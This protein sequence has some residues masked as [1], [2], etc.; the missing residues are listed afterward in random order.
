MP[1]IIGAARVPIGKANGIYKNTIP[2]DLA[3]V[4]MLHIMN[5]KPENIA[6]EIILAN[7]FGTGGNMA[8][9]AALKAGMSINTVATTIDSQCSGGLRAI[10][11][12]CFALNANDQVLA[13]GMESKSLAP[14]KAYQN[15]DPRK[16]PNFYS[17]EIAQFSP[18]QKSENA[19]LLAA[20]N[21]A[22]KYE[23]QKSEM[24]KQTL[25]SHQRAHLAKNIVAQFIIKLDSQH[26]DQSIRSNISLEFLTKASENTLI[27]RTVAAHYNDGA[28]MILIS[29]SPYIKPL[30]EIIATATVGNEPDLAPEGVLFA[31]EKVIKKSGIKIDDISNFE[32][33]ES[34]ALTPIIFSQYFNVALHK[35]NILG[36]CLAYG[37]PFG[38]SGTIQIIHLIASLKPGQLGLAV[39]PGAG[40]QAT[41]VIIKK[42]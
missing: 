5:K 36:G 20:E 29:N 9:Y 6:T 10:E 39:C 28:A 31:T 19:L 8:R 2:E 12:A 18:N 24:W 7:A 33:N 23:I 1:W 35:I 15:T 22:K 30:A 21:V 26:T 40:G 34:F 3:A 16:K 27:D 4:L 11:M 38:A 14:I 17:Y 13:G 37:H 32:V 41:A 25:I 42:C